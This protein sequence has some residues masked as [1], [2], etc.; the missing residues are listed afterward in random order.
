MY[1]IIHYLYRSNIDGK[2]SL[3]PSYRAL[4]E[5]IDNVINYGG[6]PNL[7]PLYLKSV[8]IFG[9]PVDEIPCLEIWATDKIVFS[10]HV[11]SGTINKATNKCQ[12]NSE[13]GDGSFRVSQDILGDFSVICRFGGEYAKKRD[14]TTLIF[15]Y[16]NNTG[17]ST[18]VSNL[19]II[20]FTYN[21]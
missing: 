5:N 7:E 3:A 1:V 14:K 10:S 6:Y 19:I 4:F 15:K 2:P 8:T 12:W 20:T 18:I 9:L 17:F 13:F 21:C 11:V 16:Q